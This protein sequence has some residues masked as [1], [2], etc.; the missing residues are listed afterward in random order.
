[1]PRS[2][3][4]TKKIEN[5]F[6]LSKFNAELNFAYCPSEALTLTPELKHSTEE[7]KE[8]SKDLDAR[9]I[10]YLAAAMKYFY[11][12]YCIKIENLNNEENHYLY[13]QLFSQVGDQQ[14]AAL[15]IYGFY[16]YESILSIIKDIDSMFVGENYN[17]QLFDTFQNEFCGTA[18]QIIKSMQDW[19][20]LKLLSFNDM[21]FKNQSAVE[22]LSYLIKYG[23]KILNKPSDK[24]ETKKKTPLK[25]KVKIKLEPEK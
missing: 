21:Y 25:K 19:T 16:S 17:K 5:N 10:K 12:C 6:D 2:K 1:M 14:S 7:F 18:D 13:F 4:Q 22:S 24:K 23:N 8:L 9:C 11:V 15:P 20:S 3:E